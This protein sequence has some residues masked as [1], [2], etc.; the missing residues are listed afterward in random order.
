MLKTVELII[1]PL[2]EREYYVE[3]LPKE[4]DTKYGIT[5]ADDG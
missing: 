1:E 5:L 3:L 2:V 4:K